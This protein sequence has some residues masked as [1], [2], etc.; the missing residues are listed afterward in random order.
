MATRDKKY[1]SLLL[2]LKYLYA[3]ID[4]SDEIYQQAK[5]DFEEYTIAFCKEHNI[6]IEGTTIANEEVTD[7][8]VSRNKLYDAVCI[9]SENISEFCK[10]LFKK[11]AIKTH[12]D[13]LLS[14]SEDEKE[15][16]SEL[17]KKASKALSQNKWFI[18]TQVAAELKIEVP[19]PDQQQVEL[20]QKE[21]E[22]IKTH[23]QDMEETYAWHLF[24]EADESRRRTLMMVYLK[25]FGID[26]TK[27][28]N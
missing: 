27:D 16:K 24:N 4:Y 14:L 28:H 23:I 3:K 17:F 25:N 12:P 6:D 13:K 22:T 8:D 15:R 7:L 11:I 26:V 2:E 19:K 18:L 20:L 9:G 1:N 21:T 10:L 5:R